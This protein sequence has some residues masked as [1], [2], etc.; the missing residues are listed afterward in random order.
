MRDPEAE[1]R[2]PHSLSWCADHGYNK[3]RRYKELYPDLE[4]I[5]LSDTY[6]TVGQLGPLTP[7]DE[8]DTLA[9]LFLGYHRVPAHLVVE[10]TPFFHVDAPD[11]R[12]I[13]LP[14]PQMELLGRTRTLYDYNGGITWLTDKEGYVVAQLV[15]GK[16]GAR[17]EY[18]ARFMSILKNRPSK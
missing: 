17:S 18:W 13:D 2:L 1:R 12:R 14:T 8:A 7:A 9:K 5:V 3:M 6:G 15:G 16:G 10:H 4:I 11:G